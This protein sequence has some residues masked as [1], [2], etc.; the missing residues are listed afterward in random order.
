MRKAMIRVSGQLLAYCVRGF[1]WSNDAS[2]VREAYGQ[3]L[4]VGS[5]VTC[6]SGLGGSGSRVCGHAGEPHLACGLG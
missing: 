6:G 2:S 1:K 3:T 4:R 5:L